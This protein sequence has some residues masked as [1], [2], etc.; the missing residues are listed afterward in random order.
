MLVQRVEETG[1]CPAPFLLDLDRGAG[2]LGRSDHLLA[3]RSRT[4]VEQRSQ[5]G[6]FDARC[7][8]VVNTG[9][10]GGRSQHE[11]DTAGVQLHRGRVR[12]VDL[13]L[14]NMRRIS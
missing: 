9:A 2:Y 12:E 1:A 11:V 13:A 4:C 6:K 5:N 8:G 10:I 14:P 7:G 3:K